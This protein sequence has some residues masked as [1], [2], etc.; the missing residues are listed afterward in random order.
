VFLFDVQKLSDARMQKFP[1]DSSTDNVAAGNP[2]HAAR[3]RAGNRRNQRQV[4]LIHQEPAAC[5]QELIGHRQTDDTQDQQRK[6]REVSVSRNPVEDCGFQLERITYSLHLRRRIVT[7]SGPD[8][9]TS[10][11]C[12]AANS[13]AALG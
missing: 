8:R 4:P 7:D 2:T 13:R 5:E 12:A 3:Q 1:P 6:D 10:T 11:G 9:K